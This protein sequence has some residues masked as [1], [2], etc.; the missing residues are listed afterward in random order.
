VIHLQYSRLGFE[1]F[2][3]N[4]SVLTGKLEG[5]NRSRVGVKPVLE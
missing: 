5:L 4:P 2:D 1:F 3:I